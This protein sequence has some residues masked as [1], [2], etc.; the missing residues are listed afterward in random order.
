[1]HGGRNDWTALHW[2]AAEGRQVLC[3]KLLKEK[4]DPTQVDD[5]GRSA[6]DYAKEA[7]HQSTWLLLSQTHQELSQKKVL[8]V[9]A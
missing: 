4:A 6:L 2:A 8:Q 1:M 7:G 3:A 5:T 9:L